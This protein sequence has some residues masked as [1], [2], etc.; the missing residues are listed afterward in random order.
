MAF[1]TGG[2]ICLSVR[3]IWHNEHE[4]WSDCVVP[5]CSGLI[6]QKKLFT[7]KFTGRRILQLL[8]GCKLNQTE[9]IHLRACAG[10]Y[11]TQNF[12]IFKWL[13][14]VLRK[15]E[16]IQIIFHH[17]EMRYQENKSTFR[18]F[19]NCQRFPLIFSEKFQKCHTDRKGPNARTF[20]RIEN[21]V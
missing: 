18:D 6:V 7:E 12:T 2:I 15:P 21:S 17:S 20:I 11:W 13:K 8:I 4:H 9:F 14:K 19:G 10:F 16:L 3:C 1:P 5:I